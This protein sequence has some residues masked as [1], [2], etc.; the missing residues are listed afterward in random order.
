MACWNTT[1]TSTSYTT[2]TSSPTS[3]GESRVSAAS[4]IEWLCLCYDHDWGL[5][6]A[7]STDLMDTMLI[8][9]RYV[10]S[11][12]LLSVEILSICIT[13][14]RCKNF[15]NHFVFSR[16]FRKIVFLFIWFICTWCHFPFF[17]FTKPKIYSVVTYFREH[18]NF[19]RLLFNDHSE[20]VTSFF[21]TILLK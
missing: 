15:W 17:F 12:L 11:E 14:F 20:N 16:L 5:C 1:E 18:P 7:I 21:E 8:I 19:Y 2:S 9:Y 4:L 6:V 13:Q 10:E 3:W